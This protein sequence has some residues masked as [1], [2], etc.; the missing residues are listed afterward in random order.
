MAYQ[1]SPGHLKNALAASILGSLALQQQKRERLAAYAASPNRC[2]HCKSA[3]SYAQRKGK[4][5]SKACAAS[6]NNQGRIA[7]PEQRNKTRLAIQAHHANKPAKQMPGCLVCGSAV[8]RGYRVYCSKACKGLDPQMRERQA[9]AMRVRIASGIHSGW[10]SRSKMEPSYAEQYVMYAL[11]RY[12]IED[13]RREYPIRGDV[14]ST[15]F[16]DIAF[17]GSKIAIEVDGKQHKL[18]ERKAKDDEKDAILEEQGWRVFRIEW[19][20]PTTEA[21]KRRLH[22][23]IVAMLALLGVQN[24]KWPLEPPV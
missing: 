23:Q 3:L 13:F 17:L 5:C 18:P 2:L 11:R 8:K 20:S 19:V 15:K 10:K 24:P 22:P 21:G 7:S 16:V 14:G 6:F 9:D 1:K 12:G 4:F